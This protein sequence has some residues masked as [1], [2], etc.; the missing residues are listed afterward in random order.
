M[1][2]LETEMMKGRA[3]AAMDGAL[4]LRSKC[5]VGQALHR[6]CRFF[7]HQLCCCFITQTGSA[8]L[9]TSLPDAEL[10]T[11]AEEVA[12]LHEAQRSAQ[13]QMNM[14]IADLQVGGQRAGCPDDARSNC[15][16]SLSVIFSCAGRLP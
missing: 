9:C 3:Y 8:S 11:K 13:S 5:T 1:C 14:Y 6:I 7:S 2:V 15:F 16:V 10:A 12:S 4:P